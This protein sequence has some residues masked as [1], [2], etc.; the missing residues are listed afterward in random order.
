MTGE[1]IPLP[2]GAWARL[3]DPKKVPERLRRPLLELQRKSLVALGPEFAAAQDKGKELSAA[4][5]YLVLKG[6]VDSGRSA[7]GEEI[8]DQL[9]ATL[10]YDWSFDFKADVE[11]VLE[12]PGDARA[13][14]AKACK[15]LVGPLM[16]ETT[17]ADV[18]DP[19]SPTEPGSGSDKP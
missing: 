17:D 6:L 11:G 7:I 8:E 19:D 14:L 13:E 1:K 10:V 3:R 15:P 12:L 4:D 2:D 16:G 5:N 18:L 9:I